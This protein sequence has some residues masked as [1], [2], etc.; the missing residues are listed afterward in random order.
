[1]AEG[2]VLAGSTTKKVV[3]RRFDREPLAGFVSAQSF[4]DPGVELLSTEGAVSLLPY[5]E[6]KTICFVRDFASADA[7]LGKKVFN[8][9]PKLAGLW[10][11]MR[12]RDGEIME[13]ILPN[14]LLQIESHGYTVIPPDPYANSQRIFAPRSA[15][16]E[17]Q[18]VGVIGRPRPVPKAK[19]AVPKEQ[20]ELFE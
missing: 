13:G 19:P 7:E 14:D 17:I 16:A 15:L 2:S 8:T 1:L 4:G 5:H 11:R 10:V 9:R 20:I 12:F 6:I 18:V 3:I